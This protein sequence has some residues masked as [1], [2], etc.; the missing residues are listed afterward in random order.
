MNAITFDIS[1]AD[2]EFIEELVSEGKATSKVHAIQM[3]I[4]LLAREEALARVRR[5][6]KEMREGKCLRGDLDEL[7][8]LID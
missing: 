8:K 6:Q 1:D 3:A 4:Q 7:A 5:A 2:M